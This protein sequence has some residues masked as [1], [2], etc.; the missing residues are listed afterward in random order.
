MAAN[1]TQLARQPAHLH[2]QEAVGQ[3]AVQW[4]SNLCQS[5]DRHRFNSVCEMQND[6]EARL[7][8]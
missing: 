2:A 5:D 8:V 3:M 1:D 6:K 4:W 7:D